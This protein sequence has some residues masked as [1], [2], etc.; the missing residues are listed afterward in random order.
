MNVLVLGG[1]GFIGSHIVEQLIHDGHSV[2]VFA[3]QSAD[4]RKR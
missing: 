4:F 3:R 2:R 1:H